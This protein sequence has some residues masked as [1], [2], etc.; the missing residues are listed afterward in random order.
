MRNVSVIGHFGGQSQACDGQS[1]KTR[2]VTQELERTLGGKNVRRIDTFRWKKRPLKLI[3]N[4]VGAVWS[5]KNVVFMT[6]QGGIKVF[7]WLLSC[8]NLFGTCRIHYVVIG[9]W[10]PDYLQT[11][12]RLRKV[13]GRM[14]GIYVETEGMK[15]LLEELGLS[16]LVVMP[17]CKY[18]QKLLP[19]ELVYSHCPPYRLCTFSRVMREKGIADAVHAVEEAN[20]R[21]GTQAFTLDIYGQVEESQTEWFE[22]LRETFPG[23]VRYK[24]IVPFEESVPVLKT[25]TALLFPTVY[26]CEGMAGTLIDALASGVPVIASDWRYNSEIIRPGRNG[27]LHPAGD[28]EAMVEALLAMHRDIERWNELKLTCLEDSARYTPEGAVSVL[29]E[30]FGA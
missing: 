24:G 30:K 29:L 6:D 18:L 22:A 1:V 14:A 10:L 4:C 28:V 5:S 20:R 13:L 26:D 9:G 16:N 17:N 27:I 25:Y 7:P 8:A 12:P 15:G 19:S 21:L 11:R 23:F 3:G 2:I